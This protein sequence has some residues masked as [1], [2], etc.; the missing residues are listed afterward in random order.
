MAKFRNIIGAFLHAPDRF[1][2]L[3]EHIDK[4]NRRLDKL[5]EINPAWLTWITDELI[6]NRVRLRDLNREMS[7]ERTVWGPPEKLNIAPG[8]AVDSCMFNVNSGTITIGKYTFAGSGVSLLAGSHDPELRGYLRRDSELTEGCDITVGEGVW[9]ASGCMLLGPCEVGDNAVIAA[10]AVVIPGTKV[11]PD[12]IWGGVPAKQIG[13]L[14]ERPGEMTED[15]AVL[16]ALQR[17]N[18]ILFVEGWSEKKTIPIPERVEICRW[19]ETDEA[20]ILTNWDTVLLEYGIEGM[21]SCVLKI[22]GSR[23][24]QELQ[25]AGGT[26]KITVALP[27]GGDSA[28]RIRIRKMTDGTRIWV[29]MVPD[30]EGSENT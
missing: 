23:G 13:R 8:A 1:D 2:E 30:E 9:L 25:L 7:V 24:E 14:A 12:T 17:E 10:G 26:G 15:P 3:A 19:M 20:E 6:H 11:P 5:N 29:R 18:G 22:R 16:R 28:E 27:C 21:D 4:T